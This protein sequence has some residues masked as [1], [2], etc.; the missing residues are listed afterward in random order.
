MSF[1]K[2]SMKK[3]ADLAWKECKLDF[4]TEINV[5]LYVSFLNSI[6]YVNF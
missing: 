6:T 4:K 2:A 1:K 5:I 3:T